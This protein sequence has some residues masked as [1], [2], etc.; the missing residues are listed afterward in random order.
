M[1][2]LGRTVRP[3][4]PYEETTMGFYSHVIVPR[5]CDFGLDRP[6]VARYRRELLAHAGGNILEIGFGT[7]LNLPCYPPHVRKLTT[8]D[9]NVGMHRRARRRI[10][11]AGIE[12]DQRL[13]GGERL[14]FGDGTFD[15]VVSTFTLCSIGGVAQALGEVYRVLKVGGKFLFLE[16]GLSPQPDVQKWQRRLNWLQMRLADGC[17]LDR[18]IR[19]LVTASPFASVQMDEFYLEKTP[20]THGYL[21]RGVA[22]K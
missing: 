13:L 3:A 22:T 19:A 21:Y 15:C 8:V 9:P 6:F 20:R 16:H 10:R 1:A 12:V 7:G 14:P 4:P 5:L 11:Q 18:D 17:H 2:P